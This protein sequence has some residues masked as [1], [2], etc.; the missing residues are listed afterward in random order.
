MLNYARPDVDLVAF[1]MQHNRPRVSHK[2][3]IRVTYV[4]WEK[5]E[6]R[7]GMATAAGVSHPLTWLR[8]YC[9]LVVNGSNK[10]ITDNIC[11]DNVSRRGGRL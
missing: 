3:E 5:K 1:I 6:K 11:F 2:Q 10:T 4:P 8:A 9:V 7:S